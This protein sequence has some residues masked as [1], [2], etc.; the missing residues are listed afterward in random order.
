ML[1]LRSNLAGY[2]R[3]ANDHVPTEWLAEYSKGI[4]QEPR[5][6]QVEEHLLVC[7]SCR[8]QLNQFD[9]RWGLNG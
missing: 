5:L 6:G 8:D 2:T 1:T 7:Q 9:D 4:L 3:M